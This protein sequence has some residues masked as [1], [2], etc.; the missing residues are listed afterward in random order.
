MFAEKRWIVL[1][2]L[3]LAAPACGTAASDSPPPEQVPSNPEAFSASVATAVSIDLTW[4]TVPDAAGYFIEAKYGSGDF[5]EVAQVGAERHAYTFFVVPNTS[6]VTV[7]L[8]AVVDNGTLELG[9]STASLPALVPNPVLLTGVEYFLPSADSMGLPAIDPLNPDPN[10]MATVAAMAA[11]IDPGDPSAFLSGMAPISVTQ[12][13]GSD[14]GE[15]TVADPKGVEYSLTIPQGAVPSDTSLNLRPIES[16]AG[17]PF[18]DLLGAVAIS[19]P[20]R[21]DVPLRLTIALP[22]EPSADEEV[23]AFIGSAFNQ[24]LSLVPAYAGANSYALNV[25]WGDMVGMAAA[26]PEEL[27]AQAPR[28]PTDSAEQIS[29]QIALM[30]ALSA[31]SSP[32]AFAAMIHQIFQGLLRQ[33]EQTA[34]PTRR[35]PGVRAAPARQGGS[36]SG[37]EIWSRI[38]AAQRAWME[39]QFNPLYDRGTNPLAQD[40]GSQQVRAALIANLTS[41]IEGFLDTHTGCRTRDEFFAEALLQILKSPENDFQQEISDNFRSRFGDP[42]ALKDCTFQLHIVDSEI[43]LA[44]AEM[45]TT[46]RVHTNP[47]PLEVVARG[48]RI[49]LR[50]VGGEIYGQSSYIIFECP[51]ERNM[52]PPSTAVIWITDLAPVFNEELKVVDFQLRGI[53]P[54]PFSVQGGLA[55]QCGV[56]ITEAPDLW[57]NS[58]QALHNMVIGYDNWGIDGEAS[59]I[60]TNNIANYSQMNITEN[61]TMVLTANQEEE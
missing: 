27:I 21:F 60:A 49:S 37:R 10:A 58:M 52:P 13:I 19:P 32:E 55:P 20:I 57:G 16:I 22:E 26:A 23:A 6:Q 34:Y 40:L 31:D 59:Y 35:S 29:Q 53:S 28:I 17:F 9:T 50:G 25:Y 33:D 15:I 30:Q 4:A 54:D 24:E 44:N 39:E 5:I 36:R 14:G 18:G 8:S 61:T 42:G 43:V 11:N 48:D 12:T 7:R 3:V 46:V 2:F 47:F 38:N 51:P 56:N 41:E 45:R 1:S